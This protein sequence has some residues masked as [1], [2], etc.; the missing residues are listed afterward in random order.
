MSTTLDKVLE[1]GYKM[2]EQFASGPWPLD[3]VG[4]I[5]ALKLYDHD[6]F[7]EAFERGEAKRRGPMV[8]FKV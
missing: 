5:N 3:P 6:R 1:E 8:G 4:L 7:F 2:V